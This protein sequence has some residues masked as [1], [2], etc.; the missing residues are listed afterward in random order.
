MKNNNILRTTAFLLSLYV[1]VGAACGC[2]TWKTGLY[3]TYTSDNEFISRVEGKQPLKYRLAFALYDAID[4]KTVNNNP[5]ERYTVQ[6][7]RPEKEEMAAQFAGLLTGKA[8][9]DRHPQI[10]SVKILWPEKENPSWE[11]FTEGLIKTAWGDPAAGDGD[12]QDLVAFIRITRFECT[13]EGRNNNYLLAILANFYAFFGW[14]IPAENY[15]LRIEAEISIHAAHSGLKLMSKVFDSGKIVREFDAFDRGFKPLTDIFTLSI[16]VTP[17]EAEDWRHIRQLLRDEALRVLHLQFVEFFSVE[18]QNFSRTAEFE[19]AMRKKLAIVVGVGKQRSSD[20]NAQESCREDAEQV[21]RFLKEKG[22]FTNPILLINDDAGRG[23]I[24]DAIFRLGRRTTA[25]DSVLVYFSGL[26]C[27][28]N[29]GDKAEPLLLTVDSEGKPD[30][31]Q[32]TAVRVTE[33]AEWLKSFS[34]AR[35]VAV[36]LDTSFAGAGTR[37]FNLKTSSMKATASELLK[38]I[39]ERSGVRF[40]YSANPGDGAALKAPEGAN[41]IIL[42]DGKTHMGVFTCYLLRGLGHNS[43]GEDVAP[44]DSTPK[45]GMVTLAEAFNYAKNKVYERQELL[46][47]PQNPWISENNGQNDLYLLGASPLKSETGAGGTK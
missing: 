36:I 27:T 32:E 11:E 13:P 20:I 2:T 40:V 21:A 5:A 28:I 6:L 46:G 24:K 33:L 34:Q 29:N 16:V 31:I 45:D 7:D 41:D 8:F 37:T 25:Y 39:P 1:L 38:A 3:K 18:F 19:E 35:S 9:G 22:G 4:Y 26:G 43:T 12:F 17:P 23:N 47:E 44:A 10:E 15:A 14:W 42:S 30:R